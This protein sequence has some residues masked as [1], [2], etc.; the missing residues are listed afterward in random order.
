MKILHFMTTL[1]KNDSI[2]KNNNNN[3]NKIIVKN[4]RNH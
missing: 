2:I 4:R 1:N 3:K